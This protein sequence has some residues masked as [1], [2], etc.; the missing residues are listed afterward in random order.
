MNLDKLQAITLTHE[1]KGSSYQLNLKG[2]RY[3]GEVILDEQLSCLDDLNIFYV[4]QQIA[5]EDCEILV[6]V[7][8]YDISGAISA[9]SYVNKLLKHIDCKLSFAYTVLTPQ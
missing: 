2:D 8:S 7:E 3:I 9:P 1:I 4:R 5:I 6:R